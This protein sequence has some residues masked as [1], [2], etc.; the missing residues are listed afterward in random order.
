MLSVT[1]TVTESAAADVQGIWS[2]D[3]IPG[4]KRIVDYIHSQRGVIGIQI[5]HAGRKAS[6]LAPWIQMIAQ[7]SGWQGGSVASDANGGWGD[8]GD[9]SPHC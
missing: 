7:D 9:F 2:D 6:T 5:A 1:C 3:Q 4:F 8:N